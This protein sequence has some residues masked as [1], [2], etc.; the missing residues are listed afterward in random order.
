MIN[1]SSSRGHPLHLLDK[2]DDLDVDDVV[3]YLHLE[4]GDYDLLVY[5]GRATIAWGDL[6][7]LSRST[8]M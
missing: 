1:I 6:P 2:D 7:K 5:D 4:D 8:S 3:A